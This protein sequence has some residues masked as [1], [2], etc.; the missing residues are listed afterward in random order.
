MY[1]FNLSI[2]WSTLKDT[3]G[4]SFR[5]LLLILTS[6]HKAKWNRLLWWV[7]HSSYVCWGALW[8]SE[9]K[10]ARYLCPTWAVCEDLI[11]CQPGTYFAASQRTWKT[12]FLLC[13]GVGRYQCKSGGAGVW[14]IVR[15]Q[16]L[17]KI[18]QIG[19][20]KPTEGRPVWFREHYVLFRS[21]KTPIS[22]RLGE[23]QGNV[24]RVSLL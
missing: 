24:L 11:S 9:E 22:L 16:S 5:S 1:W 3:V 7:R 19:D 20:N 15:G 17:A 18:L 13:F 2:G 4:K 12:V 6:G 21:M 8:R 23:W 14:F 10:T